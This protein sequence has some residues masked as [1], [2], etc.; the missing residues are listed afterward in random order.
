LIRL[1]YA[2]HLTSRVN[3]LELITVK[4]HFVVQ[5]VK[6]SS[7]CILCVNVAVL[8]LKAPPKIQ[9]LR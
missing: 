4:R 3:G 9:K 1:S 6:L 8:N 7:V 2:R 5:T